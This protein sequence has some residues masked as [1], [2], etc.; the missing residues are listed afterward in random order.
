MN[1][2]GLVVVAAVVFVVAAAVGIA[3]RVLPE[4]AKPAA[5]QLGETHGHE[6]HHGGCLNAVEACAVGHAEVKVEGDVLR[7]WFVG[8]EGQTDK[9]VRVTDKQLIL[10]VQGDSV[11]YKTLTLQAMPN[12]L[13][14]ET[15]GD[16]SCFEGKAD[17][18]TS[19]KTFRASGKVNLK[20]KERPIRID[21]PDG[22]DP[23]EQAETS[24]GAAK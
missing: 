19:V 4:P 24:S 11:Q 23:D 16:C 22:Y 5:A 14:E 10:V 9:A 7:L 2:T 18:L 1:K 17:W 8:G 6:A 12:E 13:A 3:Y 21:Y 15:A 20:G